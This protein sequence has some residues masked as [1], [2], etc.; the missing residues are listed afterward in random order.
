MFAPN[1]ISLSGR[2]FPRSGGEPAPAVTFAV[3]LVGQTA[4]IAK[5]LVADLQTVW[6]EDVALLTI[7]VFEQ[8]DAGGA[9]RIVLDRGDLRC[10]AV[11]ATFEIDLAVFLLVT[12]ADVARRETTFVVAAAA[13]LLWLSQALDRFGLLLGHFREHRERLETQCR[14]EW[15]EISKCHNS[16]RRGLSSRLLP[17]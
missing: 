16:T 15:A 2:A 12:T 17:G 7:A 14:C 11:F 13:A 10:Y 3:A 8:R 4:E 9:I 6:R 5:P 1:G